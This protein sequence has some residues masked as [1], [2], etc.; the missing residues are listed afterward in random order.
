MKFFDKKD[1][2]PPQ[3][4]Y[5]PPAPP[6]PQST[7]MPPVPQPEV[8]PQPSAQ[9]QPQPQP[10][11]APAP[12]RMSQTI[13]GETINIKGD[14]K[15]EENITV[16]GCVE[17]SIDTTKDVIVGPDG[18]VK[19]SIRAAN[20]VISGKVNG[21]ITAFNKVDLTPTGKLQGNIHA[22]KLSI[23]ESALFKGSIDMSAPGEKTEVKK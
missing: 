10:Q 7:S 15:A 5:T 17:G 2:N 21:N 11:A 3:Q 23:A 16:H 4:T 6:T 8:R 14:V 12:Q 22:P 1:Q 20:I 18:L 13:L 19:A 9:P